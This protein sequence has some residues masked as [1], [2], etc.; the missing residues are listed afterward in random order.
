MRSGCSPR[1]ELKRVREL[2]C[3]LVARELVWWMKA[4]GAAE[5]SELSMQEE[6][7][8]QVCVLWW[9]VS[10]PTGPCESEAG[11]VLG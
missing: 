7:D 10:T 6:E 5:P 11:H 4:D 1:E 9:C 8:M 2:V 3:L